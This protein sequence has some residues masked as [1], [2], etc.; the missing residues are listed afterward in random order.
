MQITRIR[1]IL[2]LKLVDPEVPLIKNIPDIESQKKVWE[3][4]KILDTNLINNN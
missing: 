3:V 2:I 1:H 4:K